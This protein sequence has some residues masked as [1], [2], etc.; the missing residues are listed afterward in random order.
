LCLLCDEQESN[1]QCSWYKVHPLKSPT[2]FSLHQCRVAHLHGYIHF[3]RF[4]GGTGAAVIPT[5][6]FAW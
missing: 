6:C 5:H 2:V 3:V 4:Y 1:T